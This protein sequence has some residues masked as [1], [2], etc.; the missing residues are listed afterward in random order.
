M[1]DLA[2]DCIIGTIGECLKEKMFTFSIVDPI[3][4]GKELVPICISGS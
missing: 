1:S 3:P 4:A 2:N